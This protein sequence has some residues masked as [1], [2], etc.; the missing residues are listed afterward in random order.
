MLSLIAKCLEINL[1]ILS[2]NFVKEFEVRMIFILLK[3]LY[4]SFIKIIRFIKLMSNNCNILKIY[5]KFITF[6]D[7]KYTGELCF[8]Y[9]SVFSMPSKYIFM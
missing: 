5:I 7:K 4:Y 2:F 8:V 9:N 3:Y 1:I 6:L